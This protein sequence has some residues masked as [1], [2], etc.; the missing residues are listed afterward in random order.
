[1]TCSRAHS[2]ALRTKLQ[3]CSWELQKKEQRALEYRECQTRQTQTLHGMVQHGWWYIEQY[4]LEERL[5][6][7]IFEFLNQKPTSYTSNKLE[8]QE[9]THHPNKSLKLACRSV[10]CDPSTSTTLKPASRVLNDSSR[11]HL[12]PST[13][14]SEAHLQPSAQPTVVAVAVRW[15]CAPQC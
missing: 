6:G 7:P 14:M 10:T 5:C 11:S 15:C 2:E 8:R 4:T 3:N 13:R 9:P 1:M 12:R